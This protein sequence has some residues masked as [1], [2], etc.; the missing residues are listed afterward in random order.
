LNK[1]A[2]IIESQVSKLSHLLT[3][4]QGKPLNEAVIE[5]AGTA[6]FFRYFASQDL[7]RKILE[8]TST[9]R[10]EI[11]HCPLGVVGAIIPLEFSNIRPGGEVGS[12]SPDGKYGSR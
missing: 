9:R 1:I 6:M 7:P 12:G 3:Q 10:V 4:E 11:H 5:I 8:E 2:D